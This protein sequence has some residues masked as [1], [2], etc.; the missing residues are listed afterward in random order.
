MKVWIRLDE[1]L[2]MHRRVIW[3]ETF[4]WLEVK[5]FRFTPERLERRK[6]PVQTLDLSHFAAKFRLG[7]LF[8]FAWCFC[9]RSCT[10]QSGWRLWMNSVSCAMSNICLKTRP[11][12][13]FVTVRP[14]SHL[15]FCRASLT[16]DSDARQSHIEYSSTLFRKRVARLCDTPCHTCD[17]EAWP[18][19]ARILLVFA[20]FLVKDAW[21]LFC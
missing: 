8:Q 15:R 19:V 12:S 6:M 7:I 3:R 18:F 5:S 17:F 20:V 11:C 1:R 9:R 14:M 4:P 16:S 21:C 13:R 10:L 2:V